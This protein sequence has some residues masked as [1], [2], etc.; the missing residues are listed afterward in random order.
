MG[1]LRV[2]IP[3]ELHKALKQEALNKGTT[4]KKL[5]TNILEKYVKDMRK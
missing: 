1:E 4:L 5:V 2:T 3:D